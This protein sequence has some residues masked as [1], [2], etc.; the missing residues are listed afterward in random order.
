MGFRVPKNKEFFENPDIIFVGG[1][2]TNQKFTNY[3]ETIVGRL[4]A[5]FDNLNIINAG[6]DGISILGHI[7][8]FDLW[9]DKIENFGPKYYIYYIGINDKS[10][11]K[12]VTKINSIDNLTES[13]FKNDLIRYLK[14]NSF[15]FDN[16]RKLKT[17]LYLKTGK[18]LFLNVVNDKA[19][20]YGERTSEN[21]RYYSE[22]EKNNSKDLI[23]EHYKSLLINLTNKVKERNSEIIYVTQI[24]G[25][26]MSENLFIIANTIMSHCNNFKL[27]CVNL[28][29]DGNLQYDDFYDWAHLNPDGSK[30]VSD[31]LTKK[32]LEL[33]I[34]F[35]F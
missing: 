5:K 23:N 32:L 13:S 22:F 16:L 27:S 20:V 6:I 19:V 11:L 1:S 24:S 28:A 2:T 9:F 33:S 34:D 35:K 4:Q 30:K 29:K 12:K 7:N 15:F 17:I 14:S 21:F 31:F 8:S 10:N 3:E 25:S 26:G 18:D